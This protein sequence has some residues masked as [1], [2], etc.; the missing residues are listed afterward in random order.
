[1]SASHADLLSKFRPDLQRKVDTHVVIYA[2]VNNLVF[3]DHDHSES[4]PSEGTGVSAPP[5]LDE[6]Q[7]KLLLKYCAKL[8]T[9]NRFTI[10]LRDFKQNK[11][12]TKKWYTVLGPAQPMSE[13]FQYALRSWGTPGPIADDSLEQAPISPRKRPY[14]DEEAKASDV[15]S[16][17]HNSSVIKR[18]RS[19]DESSQ[20]GRTASIPSRDFSTTPAGTANRYTRKFMRSRTSTLDA[21]KLLMLSL[22]LDT[23]LC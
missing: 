12:T 4:T 23:W 11:Q 18:A 21:K 9:P 7:I 2:L 19:F 6:A 13:Q 8:C 14:K 5:T 22:C 20:M 17:S 15:Q 16:S 1:M 10:A 3:L